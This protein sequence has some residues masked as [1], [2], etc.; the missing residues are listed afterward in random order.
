[1]SSK[2]YNAEEY[3]SLSKYVFDDEMDD[4]FERNVGDREDWQKDPYLVQRYQDMANS[5]KDEWE[6]LRKFWITPEEEEFMHDNYPHCEGKVSPEDYWLNVQIEKHRLNDE[7][8]EILR[9]AV[10]K[11]LAAKKAEN[12]TD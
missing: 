11:K 12:G 8:A 10:K 6:A 7:A 5:K 2:C 1:M 3:A 4:W 9:R